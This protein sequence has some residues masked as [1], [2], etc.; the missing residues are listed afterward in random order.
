MRGLHIIYI[1]SLQVNSQIIYL[2][3]YLFRALYFL[4]FIIAQKKDFVKF[5]YIFFNVT[6]HDMNVSLSN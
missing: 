4:C 3:I 2:F 5:S 1:L 6:T